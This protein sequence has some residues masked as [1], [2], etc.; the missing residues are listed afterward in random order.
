MGWVSKVSWESE[1]SWTKAR[2]RAL[3]EYRD[4]GFATVEQ[5]VDSQSV[6]AFSKAIERIQAKAAELPGELEANLVFERDLPASRRNGI[7]SDEVGDS[8]FIIGDPVLFDPCFFH[9]VLHRKVVSLA[10]AALGSEEIECHFVNVTMKRPFVGSGVSWHRDFPNKYI[11]P[12]TDRFLR[13]MLCLDDADR[14]NGGS[15]FLPAS[16][17]CHDADDRD[18]ES[19]MCEKS[20]CSPVMPSGSLV[21]IH[22]LVLH[23]GPPNT[24]AR[25]RRNLIVQWGRRGPGELGPERESL[26]GLGLADLRRLQRAMHKIRG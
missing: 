2:Q 4:F 13:I 9:F 19:A 20:I 23:G 25:L 16:H 14:E 18:V 1:Q 6:G 8:I 26:T 21:L 7:P 10:I 22:P 11:C 17:R 24:S 15:C 3:A 5:A 12:S